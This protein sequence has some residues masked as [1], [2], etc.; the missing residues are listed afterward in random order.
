MRVEPTAE[1]PRHAGLTLEAS[2]VRILHNLSGGWGVV[3][4]L[5]LSWL[6]LGITPAPYAWGAEYGWPR[7][8]AVFLGLATLGC[9]L[10]LACATWRRRWGL[11]GILFLF[12]PWT[13]CFLLGVALGFGTYGQGR[14]ILYQQV[15]RK[16]M[17]GGCDEYVDRDTRC[18][19]SHWRGGN[20]PVA[21][22]LAG[23][24]LAVR[25]SARFW[26]PVA[27][28]YKGA[29]PTLAEAHT[30]LAGG[31]RA[32]LNDVINGRVATV[33]DLPLPDLRVVPVPVPPSPGVTYELVGARYGESECLLFGVAERGERSKFR[34]II[35]VDEKTGKPFRG[36]WG[37]L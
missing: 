23:Y 14:A 27:G 7:G 19:V 36:E 35:W 13:S 25:T 17:F 18:W 4:I 9:V 1:N 37:Q 10:A 28:S 26:G 12:N 3:L 29:Y 21:L 5:A 2:G 31:S 22:G 33:G 15:S 20:L 6:A 34:Y 16:W 24:N 11:A 8:R 30:A 32:P